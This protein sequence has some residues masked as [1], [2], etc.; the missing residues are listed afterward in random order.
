MSTHINILV[1]RIPW[2]EKLGRTFPGEAAVQ[3]SARSSALGAPKCGSH[4]QTC[5]WGPH[6]EAAA[7]CCRGIW[8]LVAQW[9]RLCNPT[10]CSVPDS[11][12]HGILQARLLDW[13]AMPSPGDL[14]D[15][16]IE[17]MSPALQAVSLPSEPPG[18]PNLY[19]GVS[20]RNIS[21]H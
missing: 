9:V 17:P 1:C 6:D 4:S 2:T 14:S 7:L 15:P 19:K 13:S 10:D 3:S 18:K 20:K 21:F 8:V 12:V 11:S 16:G 5:R